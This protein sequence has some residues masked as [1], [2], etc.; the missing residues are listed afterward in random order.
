MFP[1][2]CQ[3]I[4]FEICFNDGCFDRVLTSAQLNLTHISHQGENGMLLLNDL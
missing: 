1:N 3:T 2:I 4:K